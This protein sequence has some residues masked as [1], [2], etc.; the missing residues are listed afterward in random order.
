MGLMKPKKKSN[1]TLANKIT[2][3]RIMVIPIIVI[4]LLHKQTLW[5]YALLFISLLT[6]FLDGLVARLRGERTALGAFLDPLADKLLLTSVF[7]T[8][9]YQGVIEMWVF[10]VIF[11]RDLLIVLGWAV[12]YILT[13][14]AAVTPRMLGKTATAIQMATAFSYIVPVPDFLRTVLLWLAIGATITS[15]LDYMMVAE[16]RLGGLTES[17]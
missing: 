13:G 15:A 6:D 11:S 3:F 2:I 9:T 14:S 17:A 1:Q 7:L 8:L 10:V 5:V 12:I 16:K 4:G